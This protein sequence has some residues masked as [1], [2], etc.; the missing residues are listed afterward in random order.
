MNVVKVTMKKIKFENNTQHPII[1]KN[2][3]CTYTIYNH[4]V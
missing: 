4:I 2:K 1:F 3:D